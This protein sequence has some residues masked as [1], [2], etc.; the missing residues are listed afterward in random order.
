[1]KSIIGFENLR[2]CFSCILRFNS[3][4][5]IVIVFLLKTYNA[6]FFTLI[7]VVF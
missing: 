3:K 6:C 2:L 4:R 7:L 1:M 5:F